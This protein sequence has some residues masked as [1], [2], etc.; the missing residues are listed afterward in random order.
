MAIT[1]YSTIHVYFKEE[2][3][4]SYK[5]NPKMDG[6]GVV[7]CIP[8]GGACPVGCADCF[9]QSGRSY[10]EPLSDNLP[11]MPDVLTDVGHRV[12]RVNDGNDSNND[13]ASVMAACKHYPLKFYNTSM[14][15]NLDK[16]DAPVVLTVNPSTQT[17]VSAVL[18]EPVPE[19]LMYVRVRTNTWNLDEVVDP[20]VKHYVNRSIPVIL[21]F[22]AYYSKDS[23]PEAH[24]DDYI[25]R[26]RTLNAY[27]AIT[28]CAWERIMDRYLRGGRSK[29]QRSLVYSCG[30]IEGELGITKCVRCGNCLREFFATTE[31][32]VN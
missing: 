26:G 4:L 8:H 11:N 3:A 12:V 14:P 1:P 13:S 16:F 29:E 19:N 31:R 27:W 7:A 30:K 2:T 18:L 23:V 9:F 32:M 20:A 28:T 25:W 15:H 6:S 24:R 5:V 10:L 21:T 17:D 22:M